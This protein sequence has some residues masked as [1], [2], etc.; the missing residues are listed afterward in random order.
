MSSPTADIWKLAK[1]KRPVVAEVRRLGGLVVIKT[2]EGALA[3]VPESEVCKLA[4]RYNIIVKGFR[5][6]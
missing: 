1:P 6:K 4:E 3:V 2:E 5:C